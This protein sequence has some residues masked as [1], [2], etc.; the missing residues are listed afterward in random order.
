LPKFLDLKPLKIDYKTNALRM[1]SGKNGHSELQDLGPPPG[2][3][4]EAKDS[5][6][7][8]APLETMLGEKWHAFYDLRGVKYYYNFQTQESLRRPQDEL[9]QI[10]EAEEHWKVEHRKEILDHLATSKAGRHLFAWQEGTEAAMPK[11][12]HGPH[13]PHPGH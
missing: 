3:E 11:V 4:I 12:H 9:V 13:G 2:M 6:S 1:Q 5:F 10:E 8:P 7:K